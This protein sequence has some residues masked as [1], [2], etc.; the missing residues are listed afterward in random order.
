MK[1]QFDKYPFEVCDVSH[2]TL[3]KLT[4][5]LFLLI[6][7]AYFASLSPGLNWEIAFREYRTRIKD[8][9][10]IRG[11]L[12]SHSIRKLQLGAGGSNPAGWLNTDINP[13]NKQVYL[14]A[15]DP[16][17]F[18][19]GSFQYVFSEHLIEHLTWEGGVSMLKECYRV[20]AR[21]GKIRIVTPNLM[22]FIQLLSGRPDADAQRFIVAKLKLHGWPD[23]PLSGAYIFNRQFYEFGHQFLYD[24]ATLRK[25]L[26]LAGFKEIIEYPVGEKTDPVFQ[27]AELRTRNQGSV[28]W[29]VNN[30]ESM[31]FEAMR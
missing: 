13:N 20:L 31:A 6:L 15:T 14:D 2:G 1:T 3:K 10:I 9:A 21:G 18:P 19:D 22:K 30:W 27:E 4:F 8:P 23:T 26:E 28:L 7:M 29:V 17:P 11:Y 25:S 5:N 24:S 16:Y 12:N